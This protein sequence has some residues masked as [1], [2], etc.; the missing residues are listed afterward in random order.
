M[1]GWIKTKPK[2]DIAAATVCLARTQVVGLAR[3]SPPDACVGLVPQHKNHS[4]VRIGQGGNIR[5]LPRC[6]R[7]RLEPPGS[8]AGL[9]TRPRVRLENDG[10][11]GDTMTELS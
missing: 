4:G 3:D 9:R 7:Q 2:E 10:I 6:A 11:A 8:A 5:L 1:K